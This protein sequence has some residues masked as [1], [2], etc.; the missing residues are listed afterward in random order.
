MFFFDWLTNKLLSGRFFQENL[1]ALELTKAVF[2][3]QW[4]QRI[5]SQR[6][7]KKGRPLID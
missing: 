3:D 2:F 4:Q 6:G 7:T 1:L 5:S